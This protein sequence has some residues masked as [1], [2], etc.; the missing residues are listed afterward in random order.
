MIGQDAL[1][2]RLTRR[3]RSFLVFALTVL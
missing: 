1:V 3:F 2:M